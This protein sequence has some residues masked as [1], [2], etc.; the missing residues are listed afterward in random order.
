MIRRLPLIQP[1]A[2]LRLNAILLAIALLPILSM[3]QDRPW[4]AGTVDD[5]GPTSFEAEQITGRPDHEV[6]MERDV[7][8][9]RGNTLIEADRMKYD[10]IDDRV[11][12]IGHVRLQREGNEFLGSELRLKLD[13]GEGV[14]Q[15][16]VYKLLRM[17]AHGKADRIDFESQDRATVVG[18]F[19][20]TCE[21]PDPD[22]YLRSGSL[23]L[24]NSR[25]IG[26]AENAVLVFKGL[27]LV[28]APKLSFPLSEERVDR[29]STRLNSSHVS[30]SR[31]PSSA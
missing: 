27:P 18:G 12:A 20:T 21:G 30:E 17:N 25:E 24:D 3:A 11:E 10:I 14:L 19:Y 16:P 7:G 22:W 6:S 28:G 4:I 29:K 2:E 23:A 31:M 5:N 15:S 8:I 9:S 26:V 13:T 1:V